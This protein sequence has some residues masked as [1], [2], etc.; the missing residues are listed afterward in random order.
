LTDLR[1]RPEVRWD[2]LRSA[3]PDHPGQRVG[4]A[5]HAGPPNALLL[6]WTW[7]SWPVRCSYRWDSPPLILFRSRW[8]S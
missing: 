5:C 2:P 6:G 7:S 8:S 3:A 4:C 1:A